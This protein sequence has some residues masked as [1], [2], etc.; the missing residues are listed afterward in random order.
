M[1]RSLFLGRSNNYIFTE[2]IESHEVS[3]YAS[4]GEKC[5]DAFPEIARIT[6]LIIEYFGATYRMPLKPIVCNSHHYRQG[7][8]QLIFVLQ[9]S[10]ELLAPLKPKLTPTVE[11]NVLATF[12]C[13]C[14]YV[15]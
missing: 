1:L 14:V 4:F 15:L 6:L 2:A 12:A 3:K 10:T 11:F 8:R 9:E 7:I 5:Q 13:N